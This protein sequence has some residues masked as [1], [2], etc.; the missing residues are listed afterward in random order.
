MSNPV[1]WHC[2]KCGGIRHKK[3]DKPKKK[4]YQCLK[5]KTKTHFGKIV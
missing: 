4:I 5:C 2:P 3:I 1:Y